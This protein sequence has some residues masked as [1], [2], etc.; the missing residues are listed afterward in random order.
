[1][2]KGSIIPI[3]DVQVGDLV[4]S[5]RTD[6]L[7][8][9]PS[10]VIAQ[11]VRPPIRK[12]VRVQTTVGCTKK[13]IIVT[14]DHRFWTRKGWMEAQNL[15]G[16]YAIM[17]LD[18]PR[19]SLDDG[20]E[21]PSKEFHVIESVDYLEKNDM[22]NSLDTSYSNYENILLVADITVEHA[23]STFIS[24][25]GFGVH[26][27]AMGKQAMGMYATNYQMRMDAVCSVLYYPQVHLFS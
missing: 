12:L 14:E 11:F 26:N 2:N 17:F 25:S 13:S 21:I 22:Q 10:R 27:S 19:G 9:S 4:M 23:H 8:T 7:Q 24:A 16:E 20:Y 5:F 18:V 6:T 1:L 3:K 15:K